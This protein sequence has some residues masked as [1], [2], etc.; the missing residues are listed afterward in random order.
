[1]YLDDD[2][3]VDLNWD[4]LGGGCHRELWSAWADAGKGGD[5]LG[6]AADEL[7]VGGAAADVGRLALS[8]HVGA[9]TAQAH[10]V[11]EGSVR[12]SGRNRKGLGF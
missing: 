5:E 12:R 10:A 2:L 7:G 1:M 8:D 3:R 9:A 4:H 11:L 6:G